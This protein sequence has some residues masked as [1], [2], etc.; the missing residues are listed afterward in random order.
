MPIPELD[1][2]HH[3]LPPGIWDCTLDEIQDA[4]CDN[5]HRQILFSG[6][7]RFINEQI[8]PLNI[9]CKVFID[10]SFTRGKEKPED[11]DIVIDLSHL[12]D[13]EGLV[14]ALSLRFKHDE[15]KQAYNVDVWSKHPKLP[16]D[17]SIYFQYIGD[18]AAAELMLD[19]KHTKG[20]LRVQL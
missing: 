18:K 7:Q 6:L 14:L 5:S 10:G 19:S 1:H 9:G 2:Q 12:E 8:I 16:Q 13:T 15:M 4:F 11:I 17:L 3:L 20:I